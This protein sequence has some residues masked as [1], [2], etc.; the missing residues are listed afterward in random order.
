M[1]FDHVR[2]T[3]LYVKRS[4]HQWIPIGNVTSPMVGPYMS[5]EITNGQTLYVTRDSICN[6]TLSTYWCGNSISHTNFQ[7]L[8]CSVGM[9]DAKL[10]IFVDFQ[11]KEGGR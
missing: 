9:H 2:A 1:T 8:L 3:F 4:Y 11:F 7:I 5:H 10:L 6:G